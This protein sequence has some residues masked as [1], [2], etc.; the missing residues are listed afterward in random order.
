MFSHISFFGGGRG[1][2]VGGSALK[3]VHNKH[4]SYNLSTIQ[5]EV[6]GSGNQLCNFKIL[7]CFQLIINFDNFQCKVMHV[8]SKR[9]CHEGI[10]LDDIKTKLHYLSVSTIR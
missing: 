4:P 5:S 8:I 2:Q 1:S 7:A 3:P 9:A 6:S 10:S